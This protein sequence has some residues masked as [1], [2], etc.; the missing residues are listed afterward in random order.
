MV[1]GYHVYK[2]IWDA[3]SDRADV[4]SREITNQFKIHM[5]TNDD[6]LLTNFHPVAPVNVGCN[7]LQKGQG[8]F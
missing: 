6:D 5:A 8:K 2:N 7:A 1:Y 3:N 4:I